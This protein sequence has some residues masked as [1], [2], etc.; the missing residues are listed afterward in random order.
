[1]VLQKSRAVLRRSSVLT[2]RIALTCVLLAL[3]LLG[4]TALVFQYWLLP[5]IDD[6]RDVIARSLSEATGQ[7][8]Q[9]GHL[10]GSWEGYRAQLLLEDVVVVD[11]HGQEALRLAE[12]DSVVSWRSLLAGQLQIHSL[13]VSR[14]LLLVRRDSDGHVWVAGVPVNPAAEGGGFAKWIFAQQ[15]I[16]IEDAQLT[17]LDEQ[18]AQPALELKQ[19]Q[20]RLENTGTRHHLVLEATPPVEL[21]SAVKFEAFVIAAAGDGPEAWSGR[22]LAP[23]WLSSLIAQGKM[24]EDFAI[25]N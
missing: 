15:E 5:N 17:W 23:R 1:M 7:K 19:V 13:R 21:A 24:K 2:Y 10:R 25:K 12:V 11:Q 8:V 18:T 20:F 3:L 9:I 4:G 16:R 6:Y 14:P 22:G